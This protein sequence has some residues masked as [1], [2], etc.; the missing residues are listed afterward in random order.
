MS[1]SRRPSHAAVRRLRRRLPLRPAVPSLATALALAL[2]A[3]PASIAAAEV[4]ATL[5]RARVAAGQPVELRLTRAGTAPIDADL[6]G[7]E[8]DFRILERARIGDLT[9]INGRQQQRQTLRLTLLPRRSGE[10]TIPAL[11]VGED[12]TH[13][14][15]LEVVGAPPAES[16]TSADAAANPE[17]AVASTLAVATHVHPRQPLVGQ[18]LLLSVIVSGDGP[19]PP[20]HLSEPDIDQADVL[21]LGE[22]RRVLPHS[23]TGAERGR[24]QFERRYAVFPRAAGTLVIPALHFSAWRPGASGPVAHRSAPVAIEVAPPPPLPPDSRADAPWLPARALSLTEAGASQV[25]LAP[26]QVIERMVTLKAVGLRAQDLPAIPLAIPFPFQVRADQ[27]RLWNER[28]PDGVTGYRVER[29]TVSTAEPGH[30]QL[31]PAE[32]TWWDL[33]GQHWARARTDP[34]QLEV[35]ELASAARRPTP[36]WHRDATDGIAP[37]DTEAEPRPESGAE[38]GAEPGAG[39]ETASPEVGQWPRAPAFWLAAALTAVMIVIVAW[40]ALRRRRTGRRGRWQ[41]ATSAEDDHRRAPNAT[42]AP[43]TALATEREHALAEVASAYRDADGE[44]ARSAL[45]AWAR[46]VWPERPPSNLAQLS[47]RV[48]EPAAAE[49]RLLDKAFFSPTPIDWSRAPTPS[50]LAGLASDPNRSRS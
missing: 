45:L 49:I 12:S 26:G 21:R 19:L 17:P 34:W 28:N 4:Q 1:R 15:R 40:V 14:L 42:A 36:D 13:P 33:A 43:P 35:A 29:V 48:P 11:P 20:G 41:R 37:A 6:A 7:L 16:G 18:Q 50:R 25:R 44:R 24:W 10:L 38:P 22:A 27:P 3:Q 2:L 39:A 8:G 5:S 23:E 30:Y 9:E 46:A 32:I 47:L 31:P